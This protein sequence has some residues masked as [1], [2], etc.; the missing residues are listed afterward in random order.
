MRYFF[1]RRYALL[2]IIITNNNTFHVVCRKVLQIKSLFLSL[3][4]TLRTQTVKIE[5][6]RVQGS[7]VLFDI[8]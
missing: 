8:L 7:N 6:A 2:I 5:A 3:A 1:T 4:P